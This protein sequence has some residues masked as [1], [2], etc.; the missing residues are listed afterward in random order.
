MH[1]RRWSFQFSTQCLLSKQVDASEEWFIQLDN[2]WKEIV[3]NSGKSPKQFLQEKMLNLTDKNIS[4][5][6]PLVD[7][8]DVKTLALSNNQIT[9]LTPLQK[10]ST[11]ERL[12]IS[13]NPIASIESLEKV[14]GLQFI[15]LVETQVKDL[16][17]L[18]SL[19]MLREIRMEHIPAVNY[20]VL[21][22][23]KGLT[24]L[25]VS[26]KNIEQLTAITN[27][28][29]LKELHIHQL[30][31]VA[32]IDLTLIAKL[33][34]LTTLTIEHGVFDNLS[35]LNG[36]KKI[37]YLTLTNAFVQDASDVA[38]LV[39]L[40]FMR[41]NNTPVGN[42]ETIANAPSLKWFEGDANQM[43]TM[44]KLLAEEVIENKLLD[45]EEN[46]N[47]FVYS[48]N[49]HIN[50]PLIEHS[51]E[52]MENRL[53]EVSMGYTSLM[54]LKRRAVYLDGKW[55]QL[56]QTEPE[57]IDESLKI[58]EQYYCTFLFFRMNPS[59]DYVM[60]SPIDGTARHSSFED[61]T[62]YI[63]KLVT[64]KQELHP[65]R[66]YFAVYAQLLDNFMWH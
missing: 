36:N 65:N 58:K 63:E 2:S 40:T 41:L 38:N 52:K 32:P 60:F 4:D 54:L 10:F 11:L 27:I 50:F 20:D 29:S 64:K 42:I 66:T 47:F 19:F 16:K 44:K 48:T 13:R 9:D 7:C 57:D 24:T 26:I 31:G 21:L 12:H 46:R 14:K 61:A 18:A 1:L 51:L 62:K 22:Q 55:I 17:P 3:Q 25:S 30:A 45:V 43:S 59:V 15:A 33:T 53:K 8:K 5:I 39:S 37:K 56:A 6:S 28:E 34:N 35:F 49:G 23:L